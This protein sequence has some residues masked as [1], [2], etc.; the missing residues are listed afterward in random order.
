[1]TFRII[2]VVATGLLAAGSALAQPAP[3][4]GPPGQM[5]QKDQ[6]QGG[7]M[8][9]GPMQGN[10]MPGD[11]MRGG[12]MPGGPMA[13]QHGYKKPMGGMMA[14][15]AIPTLSGQDAFA[16]VQEVVRILLAD[17]K[18]DWS[19]VNLDRLRE[20]LIDMN[21]VTLRA[22]AAVQPV[23]GGIQAN[24][25]GEGRTLDAIKRMV[26][27]HAQEI[28]GQNGWQARTEALPNGVTLYVTSSDPKQ[29]AIIRGLG[30]IGVMASGT[31][32]QMH[33]LMM[34]KGTYPH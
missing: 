10:Q 9:G 16:A 18:T 3:M 31:H 30:F 2:A 13:G 19:K 26:P 1:M 28:N 11:Q 22:A 4:N 23:D 17:P 24:V 29:V 12:S 21:E 8:Q 15:E 32:H 25:T 20:H 7:A 5:M 14:A 6:M 27:D 33:H 34:A